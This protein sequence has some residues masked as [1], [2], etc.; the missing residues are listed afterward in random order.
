MLRSLFSGISGMKSQ[1]VKMDVIGNNI[2]NV[3]TTAFKAQ[4]V[5][6]KDAL[7]QTMQNASSPTITIGGT[8]PKQVGLGVSVAGIDT[9]MSQ[10]SLQPTNRATDMAIEGNGYFIVSN[11]KDN[12]YT[13]DGG[14]TLDQ[15]GDLVTSEGLHVVGIN[16]VDPASR[17]I[18]IPLEHEVVQAISITDGAGTPKEIF[19]MKICGLDKRNIG[20]VTAKNDTAAIATTMN[21]GS[22]KI[23][24]YITIGDDNSL[25]INPGGITDVAELEKEV[26]KALGQIAS[27]TDE[28]INEL[29]KDAAANKDIL[30]IRKFIDTGITRI[31]LTGSEDATKANSTVANTDLATE[32]IKIT[33]FGIGKDGKI[34]AVYGEDPFKV[35]EIQIATFQNPAGLEKKGGNLYMSSSN[36]G[37]PTVGSAS[38][39]GYGNIEQG[40]LEMSKVDLANEFTEMIITS[41]AFQANS[42]TITTSD[43]MLQELLNLKR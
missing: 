39:A 43:E 36:S 29:K 26:N 34:A 21:V 32:K 4:R 28:Q 5:T 42:R 37:Q 38:S 25:T 20:S 41:R 22:L 35:G 16:D 31:S 17:F 19:K 7:S 2:A 14:F 33:S 9:D 18:N 12:Y 6:F 13:R 27:L 40:H 24:K 8:N 23:K 10:G 1:Q 3:N 30:N 11:G 15:N